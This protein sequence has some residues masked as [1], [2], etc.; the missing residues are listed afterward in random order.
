[1]QA[2]LVLIFSH[3]TMPL[4]VV[5]LLAVVA[6]F[7]DTGH[8]LALYISSERGISRAEETDVAAEVHHDH[9]AWSARWA[10][11]LFA[12]KI[13][14]ALLAAIGLLIIAGVALAQNRPISA[15][16]V[17]TPPRPTIIIQTLKYDA[18]ACARETGGES[19]SGTG[20]RLSGTGC[21][22][23][24]VSQPLPLDHQSSGAWFQPEYH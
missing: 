17:A 14:F 10:K 11:K 6:L 24:L 3:F 21:V 22:G 4:L 19:G 18:P 12:V 7:L 2:S 16:A 5:A 15:P 23:P 20:K 8:A 1:M 9:G 13:F